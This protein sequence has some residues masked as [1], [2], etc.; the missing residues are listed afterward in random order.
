MRIMIKIVHWMN[1][2]YLRMEIENFVQVKV[3]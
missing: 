3:Y 1:I 2:N